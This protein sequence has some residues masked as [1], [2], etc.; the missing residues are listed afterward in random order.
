MCCTTRFKSINYDH[1][2]EIR[3][4]SLYTGRCLLTWASRNSGHSTLIILGLCYT[5]YE[6]EVTGFYK[7]DLR[8]AHETQWTTERS[9][10][11]DY[12]V[13]IITLCT[14]LTDE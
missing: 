2:I 12:L 10:G 9:V 7:S 6:S 4:T 5:N 13:G 14:M 3:V 11:S 8:Q 1:N